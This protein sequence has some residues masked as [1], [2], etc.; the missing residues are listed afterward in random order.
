MTLSN[1]F[2]C[3]TLEANGD[4]HMNSDFPCCRQRLRRLYVFGDV[5]TFDSPSKDTSIMC[6]EAVRISNDSV[7]NTGR[8]TRSSRNASS[9]S[10]PSKGS[11]ELPGNY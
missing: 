11:V 3:S 8:E 2:W 1:L 7:G 6:P 4:S 5:D 9:L 10:K